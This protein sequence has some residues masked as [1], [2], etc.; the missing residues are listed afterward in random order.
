MPHRF[1]FI[2]ANF[3]ARQA[4]YSIHSWGEGEDAAR[5]YFSPLSTFAERF[6]AMLLEA[7]EAGFE[8][9][10]L[11]AAHLHWSWATLG[12]L[13]AA[14]RIVGELGLRLRSVAGWIGGGVAEVEAAC[15]LCA[16]LE[17]PFIAGV[18]AAYPE[19]KTEVVALLRRHGVRYAHENHPERSAAEILA[20]IGNSDTDVVGLAF[21]TGWCGTQNFDAAE[22]AKLL[23]DRIF[24]VHL[25][26]VKARRPAP[27]GRG[28]ID[29]G[30]ETCALGEGIVDIAGVVRLLRE[31]D[32][33]GP[34][35]IEHEPEDRDPRPEV[36]TSLATAL[37]LWEGSA[38]PLA[39]P[40]LRLA[41][42]GCGN[43]AA[44]YAESIAART[45]LTLLGAFDVD[46]DRCRAFAQKHGG[47][48]YASLDA[49]VGDPAVE[50]VVN[51]TTHHAH[52]EVVT[53]ALQAGKHVH[54]EKPLAST[55]AECQRLIALAQEK[56]VRL[57][58]AP[59]TWLGEAQQ[60]A[61]K[62]LRSGALGKTRVAYV[63]VDWARLETWHPAP[64]AFYAVGPVFDV[65]VYPITLL[66]AWFGPVEK[67]LA[68]GDVLLKE[69][70]T[71]AGKPFSPG[72]ED[73][74]VALLTFRHGLKAR[75]SA[76]FYVGDP[77]EHR[78]GLE[79]H[80]DLGS[81]RLNW[82][83]AA[84]PV[85]VGRFGGGWEVMP[86]LRPANGHGPWFC[87]WSKGLVELQRSLQQG[88]PHPTQAD[89]HAHVIDV[90]ETIH[91]A[92]RSGRVEALQSSFSEPR[93][94]PWA[95]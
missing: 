10:D 32:F 65:A 81:L 29:M 30:H 57:S 23:R 74:V 70:R 76:N 93:P 48:A 28:M 84:T 64:E 69:R 94:L 21:D 41:I 22:A 42:V 39:G 20:R 34:I 67:V 61:W 18:I 73:Y 95:Q 52:V 24:V 16:F 33:R 43:I 14:K 78:A 49:L 15:R 26:D 71:L 25:K 3:V 92:V 90:I 55:Y 44:A 4:G 51:L 89:H 54:S 62:H 45:E 80:G 11:W 8:D 12:H 50:C 35:G 86:P 17:I 75:L 27:T 31:T 82:F 91:R 87:E 53:R 6:R 40:P 63:T 59:V 68:D 56:G 72:A 13:A 37:R 77:A 58:C 36:V 46:P 66:T 5:A 83:G 79:L 60:T 2:T 85:E 9:V 38:C 7:K 19:H 1:S 88:L 47:K